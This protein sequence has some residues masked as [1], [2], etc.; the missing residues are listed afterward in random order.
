MDQMAHFLAGMLINLRQ[1]KAEAANKSKVKKMT[2][3]MIL[4]MPESIY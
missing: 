4:T 1:G 3:W 2:D